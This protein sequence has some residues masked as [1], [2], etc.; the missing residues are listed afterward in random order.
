MTAPPAAEPN[1]LGRTLGLLGDEWTLLLVQHCFLGVRRYSAFQAALG[2]GPAVLAARLSGLVEAQVLE[3]VPDGGRQAYQLTRS[4]RDLWSVLLC[5]W[6]WEQQW[7]QHEGLPAM[8]HAVCGEVF[9][10]ELACAACGAL[11]TKDDVRVAWGPS[12]GMTRS[13]P[14]GTTRRRTG[15][16]RPDGPGLFPATMTLLGSR[17]SAALLGAA[18]LG[19]ARFSEYETALGAPPNIVAERLRK[20]VDL[21]V[22]D[23]AYRLTDKGAALFAT[24]TMLVRWAEVWQGVP[25]GAALL[26]RHVACDAA[27]A[28]ALHCSSCE[29]TLHLRELSVETATEQVLA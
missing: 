26:A 22:L 13:V 5:I 24:V 6:A 16:T 14:V 7:V 18:F 19:A 21:G 11:V 15:T 1:A 29:G 20:F 9:T 4:G 2:I 3:Q 17:W 28:P 27:F 25:D 10:P 8:R 12:G 23:D